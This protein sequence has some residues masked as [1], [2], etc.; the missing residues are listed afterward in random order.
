[1]TQ[2]TQ[3]EQL[4]AGI[5]GTSPATYVYTPWMPSAGD[6][7]VF[8]L[9]IFNITS[10]LTLKWNVETKNSEDV[11]ASATELMTTDQSET[12]V[13]VKYSKDGGASTA[14]LDGCKE[15]YRYRFATGGTASI[16]EWVNFRELA[17]AWQLNGAG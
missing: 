4:F 14:P 1:M 10:S 5:A 12:T 16:T 2:Q 13:G 9:E 7:A 15:L 3:G 6:T 8:G 11:D 17:P